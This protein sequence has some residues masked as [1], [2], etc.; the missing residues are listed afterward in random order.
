MSDHPGQAPCRRT[1]RHDKQLRRLSLAGFATDNAGK[2]HSLFPRSQADEFRIGLRNLPSN[3]R[4]PWFG[5]SRASTSRPKLPKYSSDKSLAISAQPYYC[6][7]TVTRKERSCKSSFQP[8]AF[9]SADGRVLTEA[10]VA[11]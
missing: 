3:L 10:L 2:C 11:P 6:V 7:D 5:M 8:V 1:S 9:G 4:H